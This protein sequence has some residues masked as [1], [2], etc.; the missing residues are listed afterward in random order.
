MQYHNEGWCTTLGPGMEG[1]LF[2]KVTK[3]IVQYHHCKVVHYVGSWVKNKEFSDTSFWETITKKWCISLLGWKE[4]ILGHLW[5][6]V[7]YH[8]EGI[9]HYLTVPTGSQDL[10][11]G[12]LL[13][14]LDL[15]RRMENNIWIIWIS[16]A[17]GPLTSTRET[18]YRDMRM[19]Q[20]AAGH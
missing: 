17:S 9:V 19:N 16:W 14:C 6:V 7:Q 12:R 8:N 3:K 1:N 15:S 2:L 13:L 10:S 18:Q 20:R 4:Y 5:E 11:L